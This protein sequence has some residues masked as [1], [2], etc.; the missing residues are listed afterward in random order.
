MKKKAQGIIFFLILIIYLILLKIF[1]SFIP[2]NLGVILG[3]IWFVLVISF[4]YWLKK[5]TDFF[6]KQHSQKSTAEHRIGVLEQLGI[7]SAMISLGYI[8]GII[9]IG[10]GVFA[11]F[12]S[13]KGLSIFIGM[14][15]LGLIVITIMFFGNRS[16][17]RRKNR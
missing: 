2:S 16:R 12:Y 7:Y 1:Y 11:L 17:K 3:G 13:P 5:K 9:C 8:L 10:I 4:I 6:K 15:I 14:G